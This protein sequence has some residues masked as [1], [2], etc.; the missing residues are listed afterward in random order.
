MFIIKNIL[1]LYD[2]EINQSCEASKGME[3]VLRNREGSIR[4]C[5]YM[6]RVPQNQKTSWEV[7]KV[8]PDN[9][10]EKFF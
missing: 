8:C 6:I 2:I 4:C 10:A 9:L 7:H 5:P 1:N 3:M